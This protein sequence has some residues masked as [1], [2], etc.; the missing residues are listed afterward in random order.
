MCATATAGVT[1]RNI[2]EAAAPAGVVVGVYAGSPASPGTKLGS[3]TTTRMLYPAEA[4]PLELPF[5]TGAPA[6]VFAIVDDGA[7]PHPAWT[8]CRTDDNKTQAISPAC[9][10]PK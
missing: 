2:G 9:G 10:A 5:A 6:T 3:V 1:V 4:E 8:E 7:P